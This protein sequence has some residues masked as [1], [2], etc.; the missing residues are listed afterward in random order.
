MK[1]LCEIFAVGESFINGM[2]VLGTRNTNTNRKRSFIL[3]RLFTRRVC[4]GMCSLR[5][6]TTESNK[7]G[8]LCLLYVD[9]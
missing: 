8:I 2:K 4:Y 6:N 1:I 9:K 7:A 3:T 5:E